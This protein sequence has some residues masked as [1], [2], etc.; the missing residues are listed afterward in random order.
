[1]P[2]AAIDVGA[3]MRVLEPI[4]TAKPGIAGR[5][6]QRIEAVLDYA[7]ARGHRSG[8]NPARW[9]GHLENLLPR[10]AKVRAIE[11]HAALAYSEIGGFMVELR[12]RPGDA[13]RALEFIILT[14]ARFGEVRGATWAEINLAERVWTIPAARMKGG[15][16]HR[17]PLS[18]AALA[19]LD[20]MPRTGDLVFPGSIAGQPVGERTIGRML[21]RMGRRDITTHGFRSCFRDW[22]AERTAFPNEVAEMALAHSVGSEVERAYRRSDLFEKRRALAEAWAE[23]CAAPAVTGGDNV[24]AL[25]R[26]A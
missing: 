15:K 5:V 25:R 26:K 14:A 18:G 7:T 12:K 17:V 21:D 1:L 2:V 24:R 13:P 22:A 20:Q 16:E 23:Y 9:R 11:H 10:P 8:E 19:I 3:V 4:W 6:R